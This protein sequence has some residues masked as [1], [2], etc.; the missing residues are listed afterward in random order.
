MIFIVNMQFYYYFIYFFCYVDVNECVL[1]LCFYGGICVDGI[2]S[3][4][5]L[6]F[7]GWGG[8][9]CQL[10]SDECSG[11]FCVNVYFCQDF[12]GGY[13]C[14]CQIGWIGKNCDI[15]TCFDLYFYIKI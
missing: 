12:Q 14:Y 5:C 1:D 10:D 7:L 13:K 4:R 2:N 3:Y 15:S 6:C 11:S 8:V 9:Y